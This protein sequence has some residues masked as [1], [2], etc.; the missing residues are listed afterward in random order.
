MKYFK[1]AD[2]KEI[3]AVGFGTYTI[4]DKEVLRKLLVQA[5]NQ[6]YKFIDTAYYYENE[7]FIGEIFKEENLYEHLKIATKIWPS[8]F[9]EDNTKRSIE[10]SL[11]SLGVDQIDIMYLHWPGDDSLKS[12]KVLE[13]YYE[14]GILKNIG[15]CNFYEDH[16]NELLSNCNIA[17]QINQIETHPLLQKRE[18]LEYMK[19]YSIQPM[20]WSPLARADSSLFKNNILSSLADKYKKSIGQIVLRWNLQRGVIV[21]PRTTN[22]NRVQEN[23]DLF[24]FELSDEDMLKI[25]ELE[26]NRHVSKS[27][28]NLE[29]LKEI[30]YGK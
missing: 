24:D 5:K 4:K 14:Q 7:N 17:P 13:N 19:K 26:E 11:N 25:N 3:P 22:I 10:R 15:V 23:I 12:W 27:P 18:L 29:W 21:I 28:T 16:L 1:L 6:N 2:N 9:G 8:D 30:R 20:A